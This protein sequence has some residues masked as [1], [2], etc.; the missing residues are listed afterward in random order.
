MPTLY[1]IHDPMCSWCYAFAPRW[2]QITD[3]L[4]AGFAGQSLCIRY[5]LGGLAP[6][7]D[8]PM[9]EAMRQQIQEHWQTIET[10]VPG[11]RFNF[12][13]WDRTTP[14]R[15]TYPACR[16]VI[17]ARKLDSSCHDDMIAAIQRA[18]YLEAR[19][20]SNETTLI[21]LA[22]EIGLDRSQFAT[23]LRDVTTQRQL[24][25]EIRQSRQLGGTRFPSLIIHSSKG[26]ESVPL[27]YNNPELVLQSVRSITN[28]LS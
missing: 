10:Q 6:D 12:A 9:P 5:L 23:C 7:T 11:I 15:A 25:L 28:R 26:T 17:A 4:E 20:P 13:F 19:N 2:H 21:E 22:A 24:E 3:A 27:D 1:Y 14:R 8:Q 16:A 18:Y